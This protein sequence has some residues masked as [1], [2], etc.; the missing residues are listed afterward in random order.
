M[1]H[2]SYLIGSPFSSV[3]PRCRIEEL[4]RDSLRLTAK[5]QPEGCVYALIDL[6][7]ALTATIEHVGIRRS[8]APDWDRR[9]DAPF[10]TSHRDRYDHG[11]LILSGDFPVI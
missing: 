5:V 6:E 7:D 1:V 2:S 4:M 9:L 11:F 8:M 3:E 10:K